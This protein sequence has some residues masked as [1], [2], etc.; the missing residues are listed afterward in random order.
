MANKR[1]FTASPADLMKGLFI[2]FLVGAAVMW[3]LASRGII[4]LMG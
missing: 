4:P 3:V 1:G 2:G